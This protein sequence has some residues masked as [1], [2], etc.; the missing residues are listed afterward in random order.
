M[1][2]EQGPDYQQRFEDL[3]AENATLKAKF[4]ELVIQDGQDFVI[5]NNEIITLKEKLGKA[6]EGLAY[7]SIGD[8]ASCTLARQIL[9]EIKEVQP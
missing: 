7:Y 3:Q 2:G 6:V 8:G 1:S 5:K 4:D 9:K